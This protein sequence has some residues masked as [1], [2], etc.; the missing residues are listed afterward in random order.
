MDYREARAEMLEKQ[1][2]GRSIED[3]RVLA[4]MAAVPR[5]E[6]VPERWRASAYADTPLPLG[7]EQTISQPYIVALM[8][9]WLRAEAGGRALEVG[10]GSGYQAA[11]LA[12]L[13]MEVFSIELDAALS[14][15]A[16]DNLA[17]AGYE[18]VTLRAG[19]GW[20]GWP[21]A[22]PFDAIV[23]TAASRATPPRLLEQLTDG[24]RLILPVG[25]SEQRLVGVTRRGDRFARETIIS[26]RFVPMKGM[27]E[28]AK[29]D[30]DSLG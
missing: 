1:L 5:H 19:D 22:A 29:P 4:A 8:S 14:A 23:V 15:L 13:G 3:E 6:F 20:D 30:S 24:G 26:V 21:E 11:V 25:T 9:Q 17:R 28:S 16:A 2:R 18:R 27:A 7:Q 12:E 10:T